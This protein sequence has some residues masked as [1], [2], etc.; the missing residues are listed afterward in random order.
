MGK[1]YRER[2]RELID[3]FTAKKYPR[4]A[5]MIGNLPLLD[6]DMVA[7]AQ[8]MMK[9]EMLLVGRIPDFSFEEKQAIE[10]IKG[11]FDKTKEDLEFLE[12]VDDMLAI[13]HELLEACKKSKDLDL[14]R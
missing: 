7:C 10:K 14:D 11:T 13:R 3:Q 6:A 9:G 2:L 4:L 1:I 12:Y 8:R 5:G